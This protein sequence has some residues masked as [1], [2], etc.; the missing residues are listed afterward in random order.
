MEFLRFGSS[1]PGSYWGCCACDIIQDFKQ[2]PDAKAAIE[3]VGGDGG[4]PI[5]RGS[6]PLFAGPTYRDIF[7]Q[8]LRI[9]TFSNADTPNHAFI[10]ILTDWQ[11]SGGVGYKWLQILAEAGFEFIRTVNNSVYT[12]SGTANKVPGDKGSH[13]NYIFAL[14]RNIGTRGCANPFKPPKAWTDIKGRKPGASDFVE[15]F[16][17]DIKGMV[18]EQFEFDKAV[19]DKIGSPNFLTEKEAE[20]AVGENNLYL[21][22]RRSE[23]PQQ[24][25]AHRKQ[26]K[27][28]PDPFASKAVA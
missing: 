6:E 26:A 25:R 12:G 15:M 17:D 24:L 20:G 11:I 1:I 4:A 2:D 22:G 9:G 18:K 8:R 3:L 16:G 14:I 13:Q 28:A 7:W 19:W 21:A 23:M 5:M 10:A 27:A